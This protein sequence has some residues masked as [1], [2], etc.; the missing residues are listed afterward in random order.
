M[1]IELI[2]HTMINSKIEQSNTLYLLVDAL[3][4]E[5]W[6]YVPLKDDDLEIPEVKDFPQIIKE[7][8]RYVKCH[9][10]WEDT[11]WNEHYRQGPCLVEIEPESALVD[12]FAETLAVEG[13]G[14]LLQTANSTNELIEHL[15]SLLRVRVQGKGLVYFKINNPRTLASYVDTLAEEKLAQLLGPISNVIWRQNVG[16][17]HQWMNYKNSHRYEPEQK[18]MGWFIWSAEEIQQIDRD[19]LLLFRK[20]LL[21]DAL[22]YREIGYFERQPTMALQK[23][24]EKALTEVIYQLL[25]EA[26]EYQVLDK[27]LKKRWVELFLYYKNYVE[28]PA[29]KMILQDTQLHPNRRI[30]NVNYLLKQELKGKSEGEV[31]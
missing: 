13:F 21:N 23:L 5:Q 12:F 17:K 26:E 11:D 15:R 27:K 3:P 2:E 7:Q 8:D 25:A 19:E 22:H 16:A 24:S 29:Y 20:S 9:W 30:K 10:L 31:L 14:V 4:V 28:R 6:A 1:E 18:N